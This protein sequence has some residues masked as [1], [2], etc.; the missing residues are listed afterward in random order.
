MPIFR[1]ALQSILVV[2]A[3]ACGACW[4]WPAQAQAQDS[5]DLNAIARRFADQAL[6]KTPAVPALPLRMQVQVGELSTRLRL[7][8]CAQ[9]QPYLGTGTRLWGRS[10]LGLR[11]T[12]GARWNVFLPITVHAWGPAWV[13]RT[14]VPAGHVLRMYDVEVAEVDWAAHPQA[15]YAR[16]EDWVGQSTTRA[17]PA[18]QVLRH[19]LLRPQALFVA[20]SQVRVNIAGPG[21]SATSFG[22]ALAAAGLAQGV[23]VR[24]DNGH[25]LSGTVTADGSVQVVL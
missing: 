22:K 20:G 4:P 15:V 13:L 23:K 21:F 1:T 7:A 6:Q 8:P 25:L 24:L 5:T 17:L 19:G 11:C 12:Q 14:S 18:G 2:L 16:A 10:R 3:L 9:V